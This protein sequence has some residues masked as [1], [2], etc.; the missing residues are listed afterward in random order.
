MTFE[1][2]R[3]TSSPVINAERTILCSL[4]V[5]T[6]MCLS[7]PFFL[8]TDKVTTGIL[9]GAGTVTAGLFGVS[10]QI[11][12]SKQKVYRALEEADLKSL[13]QTLQGEAAYDYVTTAIGAKR[14]VADFVNRLPVQERPR[15][16]AEYGLQGL[17]TL[18]E[19]PARQLPPRPGIPNP[20]IAD[21]DEESVQSVINPGALQVLQTFAANYPEYIRLDAAWLDELCDAASNQDMT[22]RSNHHFYLS[23]GTQSGK[24]TL[25]GIIINKIAAK[26]QAPAIVLGSDPKDEVTRWLCKFTRKFDGMAALSGWRTFATDQ[27]DKQKARVAKVGGDCQGVPELFLAQDEV[28]SVYGGGKGLPGMVDA[29]TAKDLQGFWNYVIKF[30]A[31]LKGHGIFMGQSPL[32]GETGFSRPSLKNVCF[33]ATGQTSSYILEHPQDFVNVNKEI[34]EMLRQA[35]ELL[36]KAGV[37]YALVIPT[38][39]NP[40]VALIPEFDIK[41]M[42]QKQN[43]I[44]SGNT[45]STQSNPPQNIDWY[46]EIR[47][48]A[49]EL[50]R[51]PQYQE[52][53]QKWQELTGQELNEKGVT[54]L[55]ELLGYPED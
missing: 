18:P 20:D 50:G 39:G 25:A 53:K 51:K 42:E 12:E 3:I 32:S 52:I 33:I 46:E 16:I 1:L 41:G 14:R 54:L 36:D 55:Q 24:S 26:S 13:K 7:A 27:I 28:D 5:S 17:V 9:L 31:G 35:C 29:D 19:P 37:R 48:W 23:G 6:L 22:K 49:T 4:G 38:R 2:E 44:D 30:T 40:F 8:N 15:W 34:L 45:T 10:A 11:S 47:K 43:K 21:I